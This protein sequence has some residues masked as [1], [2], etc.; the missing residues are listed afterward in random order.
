MPQVSAIVYYTKQGDVTGKTGK[1]ISN[2][3]PTATPTQI[4][5]FAQAL[6]ALSTNTYVETYRIER[7]NCDTE[8]NNNG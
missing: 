5:T 3:S 8:A 6:N 4:K 1:T 7:L 2:V